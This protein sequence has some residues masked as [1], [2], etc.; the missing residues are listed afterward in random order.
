MKSLTWK[1]I[2]A[3]LNPSP[4]LEAI[5]AFAEELS[6]SDRRP[7]RN[8]SALVRKNNHVTACNTFRRVRPK[9]S[10]LNRFI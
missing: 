2:F 10:R 8:N 6:T 7:A 1:S 5:A 3:T 4:L 9:G